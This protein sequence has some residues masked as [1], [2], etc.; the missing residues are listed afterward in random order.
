MKISLLAVSLLLLAGACAAQRKLQPGDPAPDF[1]LSDAAGQAHR[2][3][4]Y[5]GQTVVLYFYPKDDTPG[6][7]RE[8]CNLRDNYAKLTDRGIVVLG[9][10]YDDSASH[11]QFAEKYNLPFTLLADTEKKVADLYGVKGALYASRTTF[12]IGPDGKLV[13]VIDSVDT[14]A[15]AEQIL[16]AL[17]KK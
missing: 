13:T 10:S 11:R 4:D 12:V 3:A 15:H 5:R 17:E 16:A 1:T 7:T 9:V 8:A 14:G 2:L 6:C